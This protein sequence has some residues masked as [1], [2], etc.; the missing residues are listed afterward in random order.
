MIIS[1]VI[2]LFNNRIT[3]DVMM[4]INNT[5]HVDDVFGQ[6]PE[7]ISMNVDKSELINKC[8]VTTSNNGSGK[9]N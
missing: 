1:F 3:F 9:V 6:C 4:K 7:M 5:N 2:T 8:S